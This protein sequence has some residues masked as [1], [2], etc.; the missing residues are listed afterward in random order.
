MKI[1]EKLVDGWENLTAG[2]G[3]RQDKRKETRYGTQVFLDND[4][5]SRIYLGDGVGTKIIDAPADDMTKEWVKIETERK[6]DGKRILEELTRIGAEKKFN[7]A[8]KW[9]DLYGGCVILIGAMDGRDI[10]EPLG[11]P[12]SVEWITVIN[13]SDI[14]L[15]TSNFDQNTRSP[16]YGKP[17]TYKVE[18]PTD[19]SKTRIVYRNVHASRLIEFKGSPIPDRRVAYDQKQKYWGVSKLQFGYERLR[20]FGGFVS[21]TSNLM[22]ELVIGVY[23][24]ENLSSL[25]SSSNEKKLLKRLEIIGHSKSTVNGIV[26]DSKEEFSRSTANVSG[27][28]ELF[29]RWA[30]LISGIFQIPVSRLFGRTISGLNSNDTSSRDIYYDKVKARSRLD[31]VPAL[32][33]LVNLIAK[34]MNIENA[35]VIPN[36]LIQMS[37][38]EEADLENKDA[39]ANRKQAEADR[40]NIEMGIYD[41]KFVQ[42][43]DKIKIEAT[44]KEK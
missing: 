38:T 35:I 31:F 28:P 8:I 11:N 41:A 2:I 19:E 1:T 37:P 29:D 33:K 40:I 12:T 24:F 39:E 43:R 32:Q 3:G 44:V 6:E 42:D 22:L 30:M 23:K 18:V 4:E 27:I 20:D 17:I 15:T 26:L 9:S 7:E 25:L 13:I 21:A 5:L 34:T 36:P 10:E 16:T 14:E